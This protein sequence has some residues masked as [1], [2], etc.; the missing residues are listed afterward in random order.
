MNQELFYRHRLLTYAST[1]EDA[2]EASLNLRSVKESRMQPKLAIVESFL[3]WG[4]L[5][6]YTR[7]QHKSLIQNHFWPSITIT[8]SANKFQALAD[9]LKDTGAKGLLMDIGGMPW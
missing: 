7:E 3:D 4:S 6:V 5:P 9:H 2:L 1:D 8:L